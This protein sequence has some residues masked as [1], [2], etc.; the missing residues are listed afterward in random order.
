L[1]EIAQG[2]RFM[3]GSS[4][5]FDTKSWNFRSGVA[6]MLEAAVTGLE[7]GKPYLL[8]LAIERTGAG[9]LEPL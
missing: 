6:Q 3:A 2:A 1:S 8:A 5:A 9:V 4:L 7:P